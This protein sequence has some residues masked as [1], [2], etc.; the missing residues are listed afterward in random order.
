MD[1]SVKNFNV[2]LRT[3]R[4]RELIVGIII[5]LIL[6]IILAII[7][8][9]LS[10]SDD[11]FFIIF[12][13]IGALLFAWALRGSKGLDRNFE[14]LF[15]DDTKKEILF[16][17]AT[18]LL[19][20]FLITFLVSYLDILMGLGDPNWISM[21]DVETV[22]LDS[23]VI[24]L[25]AI[26]S[27][28]FAPLME[29]LIF[30]GVLFNRL[31]IRAGII[32]AMIIS[33]FIFAIGH[34]FGG[35]TSAFLFGICMCILYLKT[36]NILVPMSVHFINNVVATILSITTL[37]AIMP[38]LP[39]IIPCSIISIIGSVYLIKYIIKECKGLK[40]QYS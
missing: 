7:F 21:W 11:L 30:R 12:L 13:L 33:S 23:S 27:I 10:E 38:Q 26:G 37:D 14:K 4:I 15:E 34:D 28:V 1:K 32:P 8:P 6:S 29:E 40:R 9:D 25:D 18:N 39:W 19:F 36:D 24:L 20:A 3:I 16:V 17:F 5:T 22:D 35:I 2:R 31:K